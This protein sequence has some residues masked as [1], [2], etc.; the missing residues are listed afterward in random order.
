MLFLQLSGGVSLRDFDAK[1]NKHLKLKDEFEVPT[2][3]QLSRL[4]ASKS[5]ENFKD[6]FNYVLGVAQKEIKSNFKTKQ[7]KDLVAIDS[8]LVN[9]NKYFSLKIRL[10]RKKLFISYF[11]HSDSIIS[12]RYTLIY[13]L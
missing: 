2:Y 3:S 1:Y 9:V 7:F 12:I 10:I 4:N 6:I 11:F 8:S 5:V 13:T